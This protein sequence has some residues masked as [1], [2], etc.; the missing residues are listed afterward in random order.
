MKDLLKA[1]LWGW[2]EIG[3]FLVHFAKLC[4]FVFYTFRCTVCDI[5]A[6][7]ALSHAPLSR[8]QDLRHCCS[9][10]D[11]FICVTVMFVSSYF[12][13]YPTTLA[14]VGTLWN[15]IFFIYTKL[16]SDISSSGCKVEYNS[17]RARLYFLVC[18]I[19]AT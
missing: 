10:V 4:F 17:A 14:L 18:Y 1:F 3:V 5:L 19:V 2:L 12:C 7:M 16:V 6:F 13:C 9:F 11:F 8:T 15:I